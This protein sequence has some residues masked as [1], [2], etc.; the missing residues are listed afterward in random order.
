MQFRCAQVSGTQEIRRKIVH[1]GTWAAVQ[2]GLGIFMIVSPGNPLV[3]PSSF[4]CFTV[5]FNKYWREMEWTWKS[6]PRKRGKNMCLIFFIRKQG[7]FTGGMWGERHN[8]LAIRLCRY[9]GGDPFRCFQYRECNGT[10]PIHWNECALAWTD[11]TG[12]FSYWYSGL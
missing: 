3:T 5:F 10:T 9:R 1:T 11:C 2:Y 8:Y 12:S 6:Q 4:I 7:K